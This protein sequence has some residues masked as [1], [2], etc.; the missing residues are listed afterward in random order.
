M[1]VPS[2]ESNIPSDW[3][4]VLSQEQTVPEQPTLQDAETMCD[5]EE[6]GSASPSELQALPIL[7]PNEDVDGVELME[8]S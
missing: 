1:T 2:E 8:I 5:T 6:S 4:Q 3:E 7:I